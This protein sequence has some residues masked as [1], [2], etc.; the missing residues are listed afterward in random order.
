[1]WLTQGPNTCN[2][3]LSH[4]WK[5]LFLNSGSA[6]HEAQYTMHYMTAEQLS[7]SLIF[8]VKLT[9][10]YHQVCNFSSVLYEAKCCG[11]SDEKEDT[12]E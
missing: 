3:K 11:D 6:K 1:M 5:L 7:Y 10:P 2:L 8:K 12:S 4:S 9:L